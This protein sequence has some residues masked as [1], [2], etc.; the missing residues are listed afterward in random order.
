VTHNVSRAIRIG[1][2]NPALFT[3][4]SAALL[5]IGAAVSLNAAEDSFIGRLHNIS[6]VAS[7]VPQNGDQNPYGVA[8]VPRTTGSLVAGN[9]L[10]SNFNN[11]GANGGEQGTG[12]TIVQIAPNGKVNLFAEIKAAS[13]RGACPGGVGLT[14]A[15]VALRSGWV[16]VGSLP[17]ADGTS[18]TAKAGCLIV[19]NHSGQ[20]VETLSGGAINGP[21]DMTALDLGNAAVLF[22]TNIL[23]GT[24]AANGRVVN[25]GVVVRILLAIQDEDEDEDEGGSGIPHEVSRMTIASGLGQ[26]TDPSALV[27]GPTGLGL[28]NDGTLYVADTLASRIAAIPAALFRVNSAGTGQTVSVGGSL[29]GPLGLAIAENG[30]I[31][32]VNG[33]DGNMVETT[34]KG[35]QVAVKEVDTTGTGGG[36]LFGLAVTPHS[37][38]FVNDGNNT[39]NVLH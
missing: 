3:V 28:G 34:P 18:A 37:V 38:Y 12:S 26:R 23:D 33:G 24:V 21:W 27:I 16:I 14:T 32:T 36:T 30:D 39:L 22:V 9:V 11:N 1:R 10:V 13:L 25:N 20:V 29:K 19:L 7:T 15:L 31:L 4:V 17:T 5:S 8:I 2:A 35:A 6:T